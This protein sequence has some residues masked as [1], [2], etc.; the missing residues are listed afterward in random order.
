MSIKTEHS[1]CQKWTH[2]GRKPRCGNSEWKLF[3]DDEQN[4]V[5]VCLLDKNEA[6]VCSWNHFA[7]KLGNGILREVSFER[8][9]LIWGK[10]F[11]NKSRG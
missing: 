3:D 5:V 9:K 11:K 8:G 6:S 1:I 2:Y 4:R 10:V 7:E